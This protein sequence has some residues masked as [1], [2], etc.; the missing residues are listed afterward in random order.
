MFISITRAMMRSGSQFRRISGSLALTLSSLMVMTGLVGCGGGEESLPA[1]TA[2]P[3]ATE[4][5]SP[6]TTQPEPT[7]PPVRTITIVVEGDRPVGGIQRPTI[8]QDERIALVVRSDVADEVHLHGYD[9]FRD[10]AAGGIAR[11][12]FTADVPGRFEVEL[13]ERG[14]Q[15]GELTV[16]P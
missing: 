1:T 12:A 15:I 3:P 8:E 2:Q 4:T 10:I 16:E 6:A 7:Q 13:E 11:I 5:T 9:L 14:L